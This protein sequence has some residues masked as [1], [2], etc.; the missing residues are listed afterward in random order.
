MELKI[1]P[2]LVCTET[3]YE[4]EIKPIIKT[5]DD[6]DVCPQRNEKRNTTWN[7]DIFDYCDCCPFGKA[8]IKIREAL[9]IIQDIAV[10]DF[11][12]TP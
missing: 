5:L 12:K 2:M 11:S 7:C 8:N 3:E 4:N 9:R 6:L 10:K 1:T